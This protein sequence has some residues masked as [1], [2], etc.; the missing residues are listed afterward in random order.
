MMTRESYR[1]IG[2]V[3]GLSGGWLAM[4]LLGYWSLMPAAIFGMVGCVAGAITGEKL[5]D[6]R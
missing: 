2:A 6:R 5:H 4:Y 1:R 3:S